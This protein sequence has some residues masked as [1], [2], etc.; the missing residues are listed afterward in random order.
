MAAA[1]TSV[2]PLARRAQSPALWQDR[3]LEPKPR[4]RL[5]VMAARGVV[6][7]LAMAV[8]AGCG[9]AEPAG[10]DAGSRGHRVQHLA[11]A[12]PALAGGAVVWGE[13]YRDGS[14]AVIRKR[15]GRRPRS[16]TGSRRPRARTASGRSSAFRAR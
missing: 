9:G 6:M 13:K 3:G 14:R 12:G 15:P 7:V 4:G 2:E 1:A 10:L 8:A 11:F 16:C 5:V